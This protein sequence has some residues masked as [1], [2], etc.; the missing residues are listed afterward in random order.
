MKTEQ[1]L[2]EILKGLTI[3]EKIGMVHG[4][5]LFRTKAVEE[6]GI[7]EF[8]FSDGPMGVR[9]EY[10]KTQWYP[11]G[12]PDDL[13]TYLP[14]NS[15][16]AST[17]S[18]EAAKEIGSILGAEAR[19][20]GKDM[21]LAPGVNIMRSPL[22]G[23]NFEYMSEDPYLTAELAVPYIEGVQENDVSA[24]VKHFALNNQET[25]RHGVDVQ[26][27][28]R[29][30]WEIYLPAFEAAVKRAG[31]NGVMASYNKF[32]GKYASH[33]KEL[34]DDILRD[35]W[36]FDKLLVSDWGSIEDTIEAANVS[37]DADMRVTDNFDEYF[38]ANPLK[39]AIES[40]KV[41]EEKLDEKVMHILR[42]MNVLKML[43]DKDERARG[44]YNAPG[45]SE[46]LR[47]IADESI[48]LLKNE[49]KLLPLDKDK[50]KK[51]VVIGDN[52]IRQ[53]AYGGGS[54]EIKALYEIPPLLG[55]RM[56]LGGK[57]EIVYEPGYYNFVIG[58]AW[59]KDVNGQWL[60]D[61]PNEQLSYDEI[62]K[63]DEKYL[64]R[65]KEAVKDADAVIFVGGLNHDH[66]VEG[67]D[68]ETLELPNH[69]DDIIKELLK[70]RPDMIVAL[71][72]GSPVSVRAWA[73]D[74]K[75]LI[76]YSYGGMQSGAALADVIFGDVNPSGKLAVTFPKKLEDS[77][78]HAEGEW[79]GDD[80]VTYNEGIYVGY[81][82]FDKKGIEP[83]F[84]F[85]HG[86]SYTE[87]EFGELH[88]EPAVDTDGEGN[89]TQV[90][91]VYLPVKNIGEVNGA[92]T[93][94]FYVKPAAD[95]AVDR[96]VKELRG[97]D[98]KELKVGETAFFTAKL[99][100]KAFSY[101]DANKAAYV[102]PA[103]TYEVVAAYAC[104]DER[105]TISISIAEEKVL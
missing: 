104:D 105:S 9:P 71:M 27:D 68:R 87:F 79:P 91:S 66:D 95:S 83:E 80:K 61:V 57:S 76:T 77:P 78:A 48:V 90:M 92:C 54:A 24:C 31:T 34:L 7:P 36:G 22:C 44:T 11:V 103:G 65:A 86:L 16:L 101:Y 47:K 20:R 74:C 84:A 15:A 62:A 10:Q 8:V 97:F 21:I 29:A 17:F 2:Q 35:K 72:A 46:K 13:S 28:E 64:A 12:Q 63:L 89:D 37:I 45:T 3:D 52:A 69:Q 73:D 25:R 85:G 70:I 53:H 6:K 4:V 56:A 59:G 23:R 55:I 42:T 60:G 88:A 41:K 67:R 102:V 49:D 99:P 94:L 5:G 82:Y 33:S 81:R 32:R 39:E 38:F 18:R 51:V 30:L 43:D 93:V 96:P 58:N 14:S 75:A 1:E 100:L 50:C 26:V 98:K 19:G 40:G